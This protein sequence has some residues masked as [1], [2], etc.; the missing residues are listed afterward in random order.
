[1]LTEQDRPHSHSCNHACHNH[2]DMNHGFVSVS[3]SSNELF[4]PQKLQEF[5]Q[6]IPLGVFRAKGFLR[7]AGSDQNYIFHLIAKRFTLDVDQEKRNPCN[8]LV[9]I[10]HDFDRDKLLDNLRLCV[11]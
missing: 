1:M 11:I 3:F 2:D 4:D 10:G 9:F 8:Q 5:L 7:T 6:K